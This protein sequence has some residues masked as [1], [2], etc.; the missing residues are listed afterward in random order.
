LL[1]IRFLL[2]GYLTTVCITPAL[3]AAQGD[4]ARIVSGGEAGSFD[5]G[6]RVELNYLTS[7]TD[8]LG[9]KRVWLQLAILW[10]G[11]TAW[12]SLARV[13]T[14]QTAGAERELQRREIDAIA[15]GGVWSG[16]QVGTLVYGAVHDREGTWVEVLGQ[17][18]PLPQR[19]SALVVLVDHVDGVSGQPVILDVRRVPSLLPVDVLSRSWTSGDTTFSLRPLGS[20]QNAITALLS[21][22]P[23]IH[24][25]WR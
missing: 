20:L 3:G 14:A 4:S 21:G 18:F 17:R 22:P 9:Q 25:F 13:D 11:Q 1:R 7:Y 8:S 5:L 19:D 12:R 6:P 24:D 16:T 23:V 15:A 2:L 10:R